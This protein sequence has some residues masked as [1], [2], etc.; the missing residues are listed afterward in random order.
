[1]ESFNGILKHKYIAR[2]QRGGKRVRFN[3]LIL[4][5][6]TQIILSIFQQ[7]AAKIAYK[8][9]LSQRFKS[10]A[11]G[12]DLTEPH[13]TETI[14]SESS[15]QRT[16]VAWWPEVFA[17]KYK[18]EAEYI[19][20]NGRIT[21]IYWLD[22]YTLAG[23]ISSSSAD[24]QQPDHL[25]YTVN[26]SLLG[27]ATCQ[28]QSFQKGG[29]ACKH[30]HAL[31]LLIP[32]LNCPYSFRY[33]TTELEATKIHKS[34]FCAQPVLPPLPPMNSDILKLKHVSEVIEQV[35]EPCDNG[36]EGTNGLDGTD[37]LG[38]ATQSDN[39]DTSS[40]SDVR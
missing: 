27:W 6:V 23:Q 21:R 22:G 38:G 20:K 33:P 8:N 25:Q 18:D 16:P 40:D 26:I 30:L 17:K 28:C 34:L 2:W 14:H 19:Y 31:R 9:W 37:S 15:S 24:I 36:D 13:M 29:R 32:S 35:V 4:L 10:N 3:F 1:L 11:A 39:S 7:R 12:I 5:L